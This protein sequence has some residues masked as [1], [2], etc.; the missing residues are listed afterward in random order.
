MPGNDKIMFFI[1]INVFYY[2]TAQQMDVASAK[3][4]C[5]SSR[6]FTFDKNSYILN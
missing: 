4:T 6:N 5:Q 2:H 1:A 3:K